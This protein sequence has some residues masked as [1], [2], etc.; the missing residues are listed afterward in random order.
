MATSRAGSGMMN[1]KTRGTWQGSRWRELPPFYPMTPGHPGAPVLGPGIIVTMSSARSGAAKA[2]A[3]QERERTVAHGVLGELT[4]RAFM[5][6]HWQK[7]ALLVRD[8]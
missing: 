5:R 1:G 3:R 4:P 8:A 6:R 7:D 2:Q